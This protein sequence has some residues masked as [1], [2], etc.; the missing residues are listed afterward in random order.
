MIKQL[1]AF[2]AVIA[3]AQAFAPVS[4][5]VVRS[6][7]APLQM[8]AQTPE[9]RK[10]VVAAAAGFMPALLSSSAALATDGTNEWFGVDDIRL[11]AVLFIGHLAILTL[12]LQS[13]GDADESEDF[14][15]PIDYTTRK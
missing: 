6:A 8:A 11:L 2:L 14:F 7:V 3:S 12:W 10:G 4:Q 9:I 1:F 15:G 13:Y 5:T